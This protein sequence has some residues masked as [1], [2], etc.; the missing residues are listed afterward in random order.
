MDWHQIAKGLKHLIV[1][2][3]S[4]RNTV[5]EIDSQANHSIRYAVSGGE[6]NDEARTRPYTPDNHGERYDFSLHMSC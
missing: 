6:G 2:A 3:A 4:P 5:Q 1:T